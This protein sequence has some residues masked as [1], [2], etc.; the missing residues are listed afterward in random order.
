MRKIT[1]IAAVMGL[2]ALAY[3]QTPKPNKLH[4]FDGSTEYTS[5][6][7]IGSNEGEVLNRIPGKHFGYL[8]P[9]TQVRYVLQDQNT[10]TPEYYSF[11]IRKA[12]PANPVKPLVKIDPKTGKDLGIIYETGKMSYSGKGSGSAGA[13]I[14]TLNLPKP[15]IITKGTFFYGIHFRNVPPPG[16]TKDGGSCHM[17]GGY[18]SPR[19]CGEHYRLGHKP[20]MAWCVTY[21]NGKPDPT[22]IQ[23]PSINRSF[24]VWIK[25]QNP[26]LQPYTIDPAAKCAAKKGKPDLGFAGLWP[27]L[28]DLEKYGYLANFGWHLR[29]VNYPSGIGMVFIASTQLPTP[30]TLPYGQWFLNP[31]DPW[32]TVLGGQAVTLNT[33]G[34]GDTAALN[35]PTVV[36]QLMV[37]TWLYAQGVAIDAKTGAFGLTNWCGT[38]F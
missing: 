4:V 6:G 31:G 7:T 26:V 25:V 9:I 13:W 18:P 36:R 11:I 3:A 10:K 5:R 35:P 37:G 24:R 1:L 16:W 23:E 29:E 33:K 21:K 20:Q 28:V 27:D 2:S 38:S 19:I 30:I 17:S 12:D 8:R 15:V 34:E 14:F 32:F 22:T